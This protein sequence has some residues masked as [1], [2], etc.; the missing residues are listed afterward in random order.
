MKK[1]HRFT[2]S[3]SVPDTID[4]VVATKTIWKNQSDIVELPLSITADFAPSSPASRE[5]SSAEGPYRNCRVPTHC[6]TSTYI[7]LYPTR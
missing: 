5:S 3:A 7:R 4:A 6:P 2:R 1:H